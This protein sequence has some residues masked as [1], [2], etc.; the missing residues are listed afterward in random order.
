VVNRVCISACYS[1]GGTALVC[2]PFEREREKENEREKE[3]KGESAQVRE[4]YTYIFVR[5]SA[6][7]H[8]L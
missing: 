7:V 1:G 6:Y 4:K 5:H 8:V 3:R 2:A